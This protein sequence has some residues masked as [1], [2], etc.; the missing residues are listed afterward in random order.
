[1]KLRDLGFSDIYIGQNESLLGGV[2]GESDPVPAPAEVQME[3]SQLRQTCD[4]LQRQEK[5]QE[6]GASR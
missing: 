4:E 2:T 6:F 1:M 3:V 5:R